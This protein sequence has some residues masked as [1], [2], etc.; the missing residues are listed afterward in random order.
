[1]RRLAVFFPG[2]GYTAEKPL[3]YHSRR[4]A[5]RNG[6]ETL[7][8]SYTGFPDNVMG[9]REKMQESCRIALAQTRNLLNNVNLNDLSD[10]LFIGKSIGTV[11]S[12]ETA[13]E[14][15]MNDII[16]FILYTPLIDVF[17][18]P[19]SNAIVFTG[20]KDPWTGSDRNPVPDICRKR[21]LSCH[22]IPDGNHS[23]ETDNPLHDIEQLQQIMK[24]TE[25]FIKG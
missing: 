12:A 9:D 2:I 14:Y 22:V 7:K 6:Y 18:Y 15:G 25:Q 19:I 13:F 3:L 5:E 17:E 16:R 10:V 23:L 4:I 8:I 21:K 24:M 1:M 11:I 20:T